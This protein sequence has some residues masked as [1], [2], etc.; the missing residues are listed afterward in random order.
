MEEIKS[1]AVLHRHKGPLSKQ[2]AEAT[3]KEAGLK[4]ATNLCCSRPVKKQHHEYSACRE[5]IGAAAAVT[6]DLHVMLQENHVR[7]MVALCSASIMD[8]VRFATSA[9]GT[10]EPVPSPETVRSSESNE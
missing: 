9:S 3:G 5:R 2:K 8:H 7:E 6:S 1:S 4:G 10:R